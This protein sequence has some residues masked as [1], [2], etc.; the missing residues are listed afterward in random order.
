MKDVVVL[1]GP[2]KPPKVELTK[3]QN[4]SYRLAHHCRIVS[5][6]RASPRDE[7]GFF[8]AI[9][10]NE[11][12]KP[13]AQQPHHQAE[14]LRPPEDLSQTRSTKSVATR[15]PELP[16]PAVPHASP[17]MLEDAS[18]RPEARPRRSWHHNAQQHPDRVEVVSMPCETPPDHQGRQ[19]RPKAQHPDSPPSPSRITSTPMIGRDSTPP[20]S[21]TATAEA[22]LRAWSSILTQVWPMDPARPSP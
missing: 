18:S 3:K 21:G 8:L 19:G 20:S 10:P 17:L 9:K 1:A 12:E 4:R 14:S 7:E 15:V 2:T 11:N 6:T 22:F 16:A 13:R 5:P